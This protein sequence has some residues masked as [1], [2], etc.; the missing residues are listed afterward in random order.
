[1]FWGQIEIDF[2][3]IFLG[4]TSCLFNIIWSHINIIGSQVK[5][6][7]WNSSNMPF[8]LGRVSLSLI[9]TCCRDDNLI[10]MLINSMWYGSNE[11]TLLFCLFSISA[12]CFLC[13]ER[14]LISI[15][16][17]MSLI[18]DW[19]SDATLTLDKVKYIVMIFW[20]YYIYMFFLP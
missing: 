3:R 17:M 7:D 19:V 13:Y 9:V 11:L 16:S 4:S 6:S 10:T 15:P 8:C 18:S 12:I 20:S 14:A 1:M 2:L 5:V